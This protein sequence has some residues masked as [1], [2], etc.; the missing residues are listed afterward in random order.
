MNQKDLPERWARKLKKYLM[1]ELLVN[2]DCL[3][4]E[5]FHHSL[6]ISFEDG[7]Y[8]FI[9]YAFYLLDRELNEVAVFSEHCGYHIFPLSGTNLELFESKW[10]DAGTE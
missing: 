7:S 8:A 3:S 6:K 5:D 2:R 4:A 10:T 9:K 1:E